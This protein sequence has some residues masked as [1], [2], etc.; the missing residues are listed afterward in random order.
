MGCNSFS[1]RMA[2]LEDLEK[3][4]IGKIAKQSIHEG[5]QIFGQSSQTSSKEFS[6]QMLLPRS[7]ETIQGSGPELS[8]GE[9][10]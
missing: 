8:E 1:Y 4:S 2:T 7:D 5:S 10:Q 6:N 3:S 9:T